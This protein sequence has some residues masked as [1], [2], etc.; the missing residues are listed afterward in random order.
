MLEQSV[1]ARPR[2]VNRTVVNEDIQ[3]T[4]VVIVK[5]SRPRAYHLWVVVSARHAVEVDK[6]DAH[7][8][9]DVREQV[10]LGRL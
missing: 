8:Q 4:V 9:S 2:V 6:I 5:K 10:L 7:S 1:A 3:V